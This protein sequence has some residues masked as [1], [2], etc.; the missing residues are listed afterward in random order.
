MRDTIK[1]ILREAAGVPEGIY[2]TASVLFNAILDS[3]EDINFPSEEQITVDI[4]LSDENLK[5]SDM[6]IKQVELNLELIETEQVDEITLV[7]MGFGSMGKYEKGRLINFFEPGFIKLMVTIA[8]PSDTDLDD[9]ISFVKKSKSLIVSS[10]THELKHAFDQ[11]KNKY[12]NITDVSRYKAT[13][14]SPFDILPIKKFLFKLY[15]IHKIENLVR[16]SELYAL[17]QE[18]GIT[19]EEFYDFI[20][21]SRVFKELKEIEEFS[22]EK[23]KEELKDYIPEINSVFKQVD[24]PTNIS[25]EKKIEKLLEIVYYTFTNKT[26]E[27]MRGFMTDNFL[28]SFIGF[29]DEKQEI[30]RKLATKAAKFGKDYKKFYLYEEKVMNRMATEMK[31]KISKIYSIVKQKTNESI[32]DWDLYRKLFVKET[33]I[34][35]ELKYPKK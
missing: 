31:K 15:F 19:Q 26:I 34:D 10:I 5:I 23:L 7:G 12:G 33:K 28:E 30:F 21:S 17:A 2:E 35:T 9:I 25:K 6:D 32:N 13:T 24:L 14:E 8:Y 29:D 22:Y 20:T 18:E 3:I 1:K 4:D 11:F 16:P 27:S